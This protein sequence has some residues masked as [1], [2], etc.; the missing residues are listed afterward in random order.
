MYNSPRVVTDRGVPGGRF[1]TDIVFVQTTDISVSSQLRGQ[2][3][4]LRIKGLRVAVASGDTGLLGLVAAMDQVPAYGLPIKRDP[5]I[6]ADLRALAAVFALIRKLTPS[7]VVYGTP[8][9]SLLG[10]IASWVL[11]VPRRV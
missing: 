5:S 3:G 4:Y 8:K 10:A 9:A 6:M 1:Q 7:V 2:L 11:R